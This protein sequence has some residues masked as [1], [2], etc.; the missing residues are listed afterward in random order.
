M[1]KLVIVDDEY[2][3]IEGMKKIID[4]G[5]Y[6]ISI[7]DTA[8]NG[9][10]GYD[11]VVNNKADIVITDIKMK[12]MDGLTMI[13]KLRKNNFTGKI[14]VLSGY[15]YFEYAK[16]AI[17]SKVAKYLLKPVETDELIESI[18]MVVDELGN[19]QKPDGGENDVLIDKI[20]KYV[21]E[22]YTKDIQLNHISEKYFCEAS[23][24]SKLFKKHLNMNFTEYITNKRMNKT[25]ELL[26]STGLTIDE[27]MYRVGYK[28][29]KYFRSI[30]KKYYTVSP[31]EFRK[32]NNHGERLFK[33][34]E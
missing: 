25:K 17:D 34:D 33:K 26:L 23:Y 18:R 28:D 8:M 11:A 2:Y 20:L 32:R 12:T 31:R 5:K 30:F 29:S 13:E 15:Q 22:N 24:I 7:V 4:W 21:D 9:V 14:I 3:T 6:G 10:D 27:I 19:E 1:F 16:R